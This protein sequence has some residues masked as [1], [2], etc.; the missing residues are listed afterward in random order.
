MECSDRLFRTHILPAKQKKKID[1][2]LGIL[3]IDQPE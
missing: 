2:K 1:V 3:R